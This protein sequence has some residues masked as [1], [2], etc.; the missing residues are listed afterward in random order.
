MLDTIDKNCKTALSEQVSK[1]LIAE[2][3][4][5]KIKPGRRMPGERRLAERFG[6]SRGTVIE[7]LDLLESQNYIERI[8]A[9]GTFVADDINHEL[10][11]VKIAFPFP[12]ESISPTSLG[13][14][15]NWGTASDVYRGMIEEASKQN[16]EI[17]FMHFEEAQTDVKLARQIRRLDNFNAAIFIGHQLGELRRQLTKNGK[18]CVTIS[19][20]SGIDGNPVVNSDLKQAFNELAVLAKSKKYK[21]LKIISENNE[22]ANIIDQERLEKKIEM[23][24]SAFSANG[25]QTNPTWCYSIDSTATENLEK[26]FT[27]NCFNLVNGSDI[28]F[29]A[30]TNSVPAFY[31]YCFDNNVKLGKD[32]GVFGYANGATF[33]NLIPSFTY[34][35][36]NHF[37]IGRR[38]CAK[39]INAVRTGNIVNDLEL[40]KNSLVIGESV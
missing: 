23:L 38:A 15:E 12:E 26:L 18:F 20:P 2:I 6:I 7:A 5:G 29:Y 40:I 39:C 10:S 16:A 1:K 17:S 36:I 22:N 33:T 3:R 34:C 37:E 9:K 35:K 25:I 21:R 4:S 30:A 28:I 11:L 27:T 14:M 32:I 31:R 8:P 24:L 19:S 13:S